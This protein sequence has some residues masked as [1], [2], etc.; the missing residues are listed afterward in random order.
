LEARFVIL[1][2]NDPGKILSATPLIRCLKTQV[3]EAYVYSIVKKSHLWILESNP[4]LD[5]IFCYQEDLKELIDPIRDFLPDY[6][7]DLDGSRDT[8]RFK[9]RI[10]ILDFTIKSHQRGRLW[11]QRAFDTCQ[12]FDVADDAQG[13]QI[14]INARYQ[15]VLP[16]T[17]LNGYLVLSLDGQLPKRPLTDEQIIQLAVMIEKPIVITGSLEDR[18]LADQIGQASG[19]AV[20]PTCGDLNGSEI[21]SIVG[22]AQGLIGF[23]SLW[24]QVSSALSIVQRVIS[25]PLDADD[26]QQHVLWARSLFLNIHE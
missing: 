5:E 15:E 23:G 11:L 22:H 9:R 12:L 21:A 17:F 24:N 8:R 4:Y 14:Q 3:E 19:C 26:L 13:E 1:H 10:K 25:S 7:I 16:S 20:F 18:H 6:L 2:P